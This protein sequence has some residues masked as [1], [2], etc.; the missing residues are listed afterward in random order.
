MNDYRKPVVI[1]HEAELALLDFELLEIPQGG[2]HCGYHDGQEA[3]LVLLDGAC[4]VRVGKWEATGQRAGVF[5]E[6]ATAFYVPVGECYEVTATR[7]SQV[8]VC[9]ARA[10][11]KRSPFVVRPSDVRGRTVG[12]GQYERMVYDIVGTDAEA[13]RILV[14]E[15]IN[16]PGNWSSFPPH[17]HDVEEAGV[18]AQMEEI[19]YFRVDPPQGFG[20]QR[21]Y[22]E[23]RTL[24]TAIVVMDGMRVNIPFGYHPVCVMPGYRLYYL[25]FMGGKGRELRPRTQEKYAGLL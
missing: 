24:D 4:R 19:Y 16:P 5:D 17:K 6:Q 1:G 22:S 23:D 21:L 11:G 3:V 15:T 8:A 25:W 2:L 12:R 7:E 20:F 18:E 10:S 14:G 9:L 13:E